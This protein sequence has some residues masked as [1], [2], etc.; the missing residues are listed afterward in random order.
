MT[1]PAPAPSH[2]KGAFLLVFRLQL[3]LSPEISDVLINVAD[4]RAQQHQVIG[5]S[6]APV[7]QKIKSA[8]AFEIFES[9]LQL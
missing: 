7:S 4:C 6:E 8:L 1:G 3:N 2:A 5:R 9:R